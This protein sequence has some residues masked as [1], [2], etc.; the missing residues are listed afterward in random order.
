M[1][2]KSSKEEDDMADKSRNNQSRVVQSKSGDNLIKSL[3]KSRY[4][5]H[6]RSGAGA[7]YTN[8]LADS[9]NAILLS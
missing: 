7:I 5:A 2:I 9:K 4:Q 1:K 6:K 3:S 8:Y